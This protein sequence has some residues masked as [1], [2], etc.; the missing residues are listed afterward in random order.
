MAE[1]KET[2][3]NYFLPVSF[4]KGQYRWH[5]FMEIAVL[6]DIIG[7]ISNEFI[8]YGEGIFEKSWAPN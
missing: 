2:G 3:R 8:P 6:A 1:Y 5:L 4:T 7:G